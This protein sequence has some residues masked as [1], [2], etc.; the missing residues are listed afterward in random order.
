MP[1]SSLEGKEETLE[2]IKSNTYMIKTILDVGAGEGTYANLLKDVDVEINALEVWLPYIGK[3]DL[4][5]KY[6]S[7]QIADARQWT[8]WNYD[9]IIFGDILE[10]MTKDE[11]VAIWKQ[12]SQEAKYAIISIPIIHYPQGHEHGNPYE[13]HIKND[14]TTEEVLET[15]SNIIKY[16]EYGTVGV[17]YAKF[18]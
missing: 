12:A 8:N 7:V 11:A 5:S 10:H 18:M 13:E 1:S 14:W 2:W 4:L 16:D 15:F 6:K 3:Y 9:L 17:F